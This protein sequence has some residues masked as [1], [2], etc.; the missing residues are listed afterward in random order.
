MWT[1]H[2]VKFPRTD[3]L[4]QLCIKLLFW[5]P[6]SKSFLINI[7]RKEDE[8]EDWTN[9]LSSATISKHGKKF[10]CRWNNLFNLSIHIIEL[11]ILL[12]LFQNSLFQW[13]SE[14][15][16]CF[17][18]CKNF[19]ASEQTIFRYGPLHLIILWRKFTK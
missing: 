4:V 17:G 18:I 7:H 15:R 12:I 10:Q 5:L 13:I 14:F 8:F 19:C 6:A 9:I 11:F 1:F 3:V 16:P 2:G